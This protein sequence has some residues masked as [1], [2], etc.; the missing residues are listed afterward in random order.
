MQNVSKILV[1][2]VGVV[3]FGDPVTSGYIISGLLLS[4]GGSCIYGLCQISAKAEGQD[5]KTE[6]MPLLKPVAGTAGKAV[7]FRPGKK[8][9]PGGGAAPDAAQSKV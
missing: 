9:A 5:T 7:L 4:L 1:V 8:D 3:F 6:K 2:C